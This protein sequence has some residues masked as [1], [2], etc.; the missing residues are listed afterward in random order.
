LNKKDTLARALKSAAQK[1]TTPAAAESDISGRVLIAGH[2]DPS[3]RSALKM[4]EARTGRK[5]RVL[6][7]E[8]FNMILEKY[9]LPAAFVEN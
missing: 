8:A 1:K 3:V 4:L 2:F 5:L 7:G 9:G 6:M